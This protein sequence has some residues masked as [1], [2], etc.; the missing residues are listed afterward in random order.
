MKLYVANAAKQVIDL[1]C[2][3]PGLGS[4]YRQTIPIGC[5]IVVGGDL[6][7]TQVNEVV[8]QLSGYGLTKYDELDRAKPFVGLCYAVDRPVPNKRILFAMEHNAKVL[9]ERG[10]EMRAQAAV[11]TN[12]AIERTLVEEG[13]GNIEALDVTVVEEENRHGPSNPEPIAEGVLVTKDPDIRP[14]KG[15]AKSRKGK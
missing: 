6:D 8:R 10:K 4:L 11:A 12:N 13:L 1:T 5:Q 9:V 7:L 14:G 3:I 15:N 2:R